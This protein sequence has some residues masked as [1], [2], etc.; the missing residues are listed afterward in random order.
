MFCMVSNLGCSLN[1]TPS[2]FGRRLAVFVCRQEKKQSALNR[3]VPHQDA[4]LNRIVVG[5]S[6][7]CIC[8]CTPQARRVNL[9]FASCRISQTECVDPATPV[10]LDVNTSNAVRRGPGPE[11]F[12][13][14]QSSQWFV[15]ARAGC[16]RGMSRDVLP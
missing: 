8:R 4:N 1:D 12:V 9:R 15:P 6:G 11:P 10:V 7:P 14:R 16:V 2:S 5:V 3:P 13:C